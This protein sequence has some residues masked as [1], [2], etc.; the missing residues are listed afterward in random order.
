MQDNIVACVKR[1]HYKSKKKLTK[2]F[3]SFWPSSA[4]WRNWF[5]SESHFDHFLLLRSC[6]FFLHFYL[7][8]WKL[9]FHLLPLCFFTVK[10]LTAKFET[11]K[12]HSVLWDHS[13][14]VV[15]DFTHR[16]YHL[17]LIWIMLILNLYKIKLWLGQCDVCLAFDSSLT[18]V[19]INRTVEAWN[20]PHVVHKNHW[21]LDVCSFHQTETI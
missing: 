5:H 14:R 7:S 1:K 4:K 3:F 20:Y 18:K 12:P 9:Y 17:W 13:Q 21:F 6:F 10:L 11:A 19:D 16:N 2:Y 15:T 8:L